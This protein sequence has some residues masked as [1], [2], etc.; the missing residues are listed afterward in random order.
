MNLFHVHQ[1]FH[2]VGH[3]TFLTGM[4]EK[5]SNKV[6]SWIYDCGSKRS[7]AVKNALARIKSWK[8][9]SDP[10]DLLVLSHF[11]D[12]HVNGLE[13]LLKQQRVTCLVMPFSDWQQR[14][15]E[16]AIG[17]AKG[18]T[19]ST[20]HLQ[21]DPVGWL[22]STGLIERVETLLLIQ[23]GRSEPN[24]EPI[25]LTPLPTGHNHRNENNNI[26]EDETVESVLSELRLG[27][28]GK[29]NSIKVEILPHQHPVRKTALPME[30]MFYN[31]ELSLSLIH[32]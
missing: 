19:P 12:D 4:A 22:E 9:W 11:D 15:R 28:T 26:L 7:Q 1:R 17:G 32:I 8:T 24:A 10:V 27:S 5:D 16:V 14:L 20:A 18:V 25:N 30:F 31:A 2:A 6:Y 23:G 21:L 13:D 29:G 3:G